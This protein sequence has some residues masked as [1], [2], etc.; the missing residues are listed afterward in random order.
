[1]ALSSFI[2]LLLESFTT[3]LWIPELSNCSKLYWQDCTV[4]KFELIVCPC[5]V[6]WISSDST[7]VPIDE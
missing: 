6:N 5:T 2:E 1:M 7:K 4:P 3:L